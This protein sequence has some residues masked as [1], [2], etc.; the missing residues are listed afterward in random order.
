MKCL[1][2]DT[3]IYNDLSTFA[4]KHLDDNQSLIV[5]PFHW[6]TKTFQGIRIFINREL[7]ELQ[8]A[9]EDSIE[10]L[11]PGGRLAV[12][13]FHSLEDRAVKRFIRDASREPEQYRGLPS[14]PAEFRPPLRTIGKAVAPAEE[15]I[16]ANPRARS[17]RLRVAERLP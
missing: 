3:L 2:L 1:T 17:A 10:L 5:F 14:I 8:T 12:I 13:S 7:E 11:R 4:S 9:L 15:E 6:E 16:A